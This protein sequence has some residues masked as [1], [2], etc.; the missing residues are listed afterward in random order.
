MKSA[1]CVDLLRRRCPIHAEIAEPLLGEE[2]VERDD[3]HA[4]ALRAGRDEL[5]DAAEAEDAEH[6]AVEFDAGEL[7]AFPRSAG[8][9]RMCLRD[10]AGES[11]QQSHGVLGRGDDVGLRR[12]RD[13][14][15]LPGGGVD[16]D[17]V[18]PDARAARRPSAASPWPA[19]RRRPA[20]PSG[21]G[22]RRSRRSALRGRRGTR[23]VPRS[24]SNPASRSRLMPDSPMFSATST[25][26]G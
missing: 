4:E 2:R 17:V 14:H 13:D 7:A 11:E 22:C 26:I 9:G 10:V 3:A 8:E 15:A 6:L 1:D 25:F 23:S 18:D 5:A 20:W 12:V 19:G 21:S 24:T 16:V